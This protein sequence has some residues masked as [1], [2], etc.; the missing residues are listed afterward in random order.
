MT[1]AVNN[2]V[3]KCVQFFSCYIFK[4]SLGVYSECLGQCKRLITKKLL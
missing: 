1:Y 3:F 2:K 4:L